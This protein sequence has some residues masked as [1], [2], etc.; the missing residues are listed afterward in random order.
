VC[1]TGSPTHQLSPIDDTPELERYTRA[2]G[3]VNESDRTIPRGSRLTRL[4]YS[5]LTLTLVTLDTAIIF[6]FLQVA[7][8]R[9]INPPTTWTQVE[10]AMEIGAWP[11]R[12]WRSLAELGR[13]PDAMVA[14]ED[15]RFWTHHGFDWEAIDK[16]MAH[17]RANPQRT[18]GASSISQQVARNVFLWQGRSWLRKGLE[19][20]YTVLIEAMLPKERILEIYAN[21]AETGPDC[22]GAEAGAQRWFNRSAASL[23][24]HQAATIA[25]MLPA[26]QR[27][28]PRDSR[29][30]KRA[31]WISANPVRRGQP[32]GK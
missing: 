25:A 13:V 24:A 28:T 22:F 6:T 9:V 32:P 31:R 12:R 14:S 17:N 29:V 20:Y 2:G 27:W 19:T 7:S 26:P 11:T 30:Q 23:D 3:R 15:Q 21:V 18:R 4:A 1:L 10:R 16:A 5:L 8:L